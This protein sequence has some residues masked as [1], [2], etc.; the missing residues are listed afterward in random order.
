M[1]KTLTKPLLLVLLFI[2]SF[3]YA[4]K[5]K[6]ENCG[7]DDILRENPSLKKYLDSLEAD[8]SRKKAKSSFSSSLDMTTV[9]TVPLVFHV[10]HLG[11]PVGTGSNV[12]EVN[13]QATVDRLNTI[14]RATGSH[15]G[16]TPD[17]KIQFVL[18]SFDENCNPTNGIVR[19]DGRSITGYEASGVSSSNYTMHQA[20]R[21]LSNWNT[22][23]YIN[24]RLCHNIPNAGGFAYYLGDIFMPSNS[25]YYEYKYTWA[26]EMGHSLNLL[27][28]FEG[29][30]DNQYCPV[31]TDPENDG[32]KIS[33]TDP[34][35]KWDGCN[36]SATN[37]CTGNPFGNVLKNFMSYS[38]DEHFT[39]KQ[40]ERMR[41][42]LVNYRPGLITSK[43]VTGITSP[44][45]TNAIV[46]CSNGVSTLSATGCSGT[47]N[48]YSTP[49]GGTSLSTNASY[50]TPYLTSNTTYYVSCTETGC[51][52]SQR[53]SAQVVIDNVFPNSSCNVTAPNG[54]SIYYG[55]SNF[56]MGEINYTGSSSQIDGT[57]YLDKSCERYDFYADSDYSF[58]LVSTWGNNMAG[59][60]YIDFNNDGDFEDSGETV[61]NVPGYFPN[62]IGIIA[63]PNTAVKNTYLRMRVLMDGG[64]PTTPCSLPGSSGLGSGMAID[65][66][67]RIIEPCTTKPTLSASAEII[68]S[69][70]STTLIATGCSGIITWSNGLGT[71]T[72]K[73][74]SPS[75]TTVYLAFCSIGTCSSGYS[76][77][78]VLVNPTPYCLSSALD[79][80]DSE[81]LNV[82][83][84]SLNNSSTC[85]TTGTTG[86]IQGRY[87][88]FSHLSAPSFNAGATI[89]YSIEAGSCGGNYPKAVKIF[90]DFNKNGSFDDPGEMVGGSTS[91]M[92][93]THM[94]T[95]NFVVPV[96]AAAGET[97]MRVVL[98]E[99]SNLASITSCG[100]YNWGETED[101]KVNIVSTP[102]PPT[103]THSGSI[104]SGTYKAAQTIQSTANVP[105]GTVYQAGNS[106]TLLP[107]FQ[108][109]DNEVFEARIGGCD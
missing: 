17:I 67:I 33:D 13:V 106:I 73:T 65:Y 72:S 103:L 44:P 29:D 58:N 50:D 94:V 96:T 78:K 49:S 69:G 80:S 68:T 15:S 89:P 24:V 88:N 60:V 90:I 41:Y 86:S 1:Q 42:A 87:S 3:T 76:S 81:I 91:A 95:G 28:T 63:I 47:Y 5:D 97:Y 2:S 101:Y 34:H 19:V 43:G 39:P 98:V 20:M 109:G 59:R 85:S 84:G 40:M 79:H 16:L 9:Y 100:T 71:G 38:C 56:T 27:H 14:F 25:L 31:N 93:S 52:V 7:T 53:A 82:T 18:A 108:A 74:V 92:A 36:Y 75:S 57:N 83:V 37:P 61:Y 105:T 48:W 102:C 30:G 46:R 32:D 6:P 104:A 8:F 54:L 66:A 23:Q 45:I 10:Y 77:I 4:Q 26:H 62:H 12:S 99:T 64:N 22:S 35:K 11:E 70:T 21:T 51:G 107:D 55:I